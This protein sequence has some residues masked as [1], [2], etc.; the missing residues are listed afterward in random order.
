M[1]PQINDRGH[2]KISF[3]LRFLSIVCVQEK[4]QEARRVGLQS[5]NCELKVREL[6]I[7][8]EGLNVKEESRA[9]V[10]LVYTTRKAYTAKLGS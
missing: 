3:F 6:D 1:T 7:C 2:K 4:G 8:V 10:E 5:I 9:T